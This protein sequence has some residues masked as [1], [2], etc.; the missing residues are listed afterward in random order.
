MKVPPLA[1]SPFIRA[2]AAIVLALGFFA[3]EAHT[4]VLLKVTFD[5]DG[6]TGSEPG[7]AADPYRVSTGPD[8]D[9]IGG[10]ITAINRVGTDPS[11]PNVV[12]ST[13]PQGGLALSLAGTES[14]GYAVEGGYGIMAVTYEVLVNVAE[15]SGYQSIFRQANQAGTS[16]SFVSANWSLMI[17]CITTLQISENGCIWPRRWFGMERTRSASCTSMGSYWARIPEQTV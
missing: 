8:G 5:N 14:S 9:I 11:T 17:S 6:P 1:T 16:L 10:S 3:T 4:S 13:G 12:T 7:V 2:S 15:T